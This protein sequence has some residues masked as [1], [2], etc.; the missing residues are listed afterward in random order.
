MEEVD[1]GN[2]VITQVLRKLFSGRW[3]FT[4]AIA[5]VFVRLSW[6]GTL[7]PDEVVKIIL[8][9]VTFYFTKQMNGGGNG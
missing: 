6:V 9:G 8:V 5:I 7:P 2:Q 4:V 3:I 1:N